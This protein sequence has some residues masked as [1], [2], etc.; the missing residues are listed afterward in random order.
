MNKYPKGTIMEHS[1]NG[2]EYIYIGEA[3]YSDGIGHLPHQGEYHGTA[4]HTES[5]TLVSLFHN[6]RTDRYYYL[7]I[8]PEMVQ[9]TVTLYQ[10]NYD[11]KETWVRESDMFHGMR[12]GV[13]RF[14]VKEVGD[15]Y[16]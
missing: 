3:T 12:D 9:G 11:S 14:R 16:E 2:K 6:P 5:K 1:G 7:T 13:P 8:W 4:I 15:I 10:S